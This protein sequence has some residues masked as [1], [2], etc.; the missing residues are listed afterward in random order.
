MIR[1]NLGFAQGAPIYIPHAR[2]EQRRQIRNSLDLVN[3]VHVMWIQL[4]AVL[5]IF[6]SWS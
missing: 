5:P 1:L 6:R 3:S 4:D 2:E